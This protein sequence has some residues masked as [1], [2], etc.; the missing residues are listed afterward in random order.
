MSDF[1]LIVPEGWVELPD[2]G[3][4]AGTVFSTEFLVF[5]IE[6]ESWGD[7]GFLLLSMGLLPDAKEVSNARLVQ[8]ETGYRFWVKF[9]DVVAPV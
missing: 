4:S 9:I 3:N 7:I 8:T 5:S 1:L 2:V 6:Q